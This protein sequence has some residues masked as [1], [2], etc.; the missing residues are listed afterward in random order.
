MSNNSWEI[1]RSRRDFLRIGSGVLISSALAGCGGGSAVLP[2]GTENQ[3]ASRGQGRVSLNISWPAATGSRGAGRYIP[4]YAQSLYFELYQQSTPDMRYKL[5]ADRPSNLPSMQTVEFDALLP[6]GTYVLAGVARVGMNGQGGTVASATATINVMPNVITTVS[7]TLNSTIK[8]IQI[9]NSQPLIAQLNRTIAVFGQAVDPDGKIVVVPT[10]GL[11]WKILSGANLISISPEGTLT[12]LAL[13]TAQIQLVEPGA[14]I[15]SPIATV[16]V[17]Q[18]LTPS[19]TTYISESFYNGG[20]DN[21]HGSDPDMF[22]IG[23]TNGFLSYPLIQFDLTPFAG[24]QIQGATVTFSLYLSGGHPGGN[25]QPRTVSVHNILTSWLASTAT[26]NN[27]GAIPGVQFGTDA[28]AA[29]DAQTVIYPL[30]GYVSWAIPSSVVQQWIDNPSS[31]HGLL[32]NNQVTVDNYDLDFSPKGA[33][34]PPILA[35]STK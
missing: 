11:Q 5:T 28:G 6:V 31:N 35:F 16:Q 30:A 25:G 12:G 27:F 9:L 10:G 8:A 33:A 14:N 3:G 2:S 20:A 7:L 22:A 18:A 4:P 1:N 32:V 24:Q 29:L 19:Q 21:T 34:N 15:V 17:V 13:G 26:Y 23:A